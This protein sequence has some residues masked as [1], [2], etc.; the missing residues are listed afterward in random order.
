MA[1][2]QRKHR[3]DTQKEI[4]RRDTQNVNTKACLLNDLL[5]K[6]LKDN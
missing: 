2:T 1:R 6:I 5:K 4:L 3:G